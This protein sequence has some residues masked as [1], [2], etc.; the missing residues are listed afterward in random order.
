MTGEDIKTTTWKLSTHCMR[1]SCVLCTSRTQCDM[2]TCDGH[3][4]IVCMKY[5][6]PI[7]SWVHGLT[8]F[9]SS[10]LPLLMLW[11]QYSVKL[12]HYRA[13]VG[14]ICIKP[15]QSNRCE[16]NLWMLRRQLMFPDPTDSTRVLAQ[17]NRCMHIR[18]GRRR[19][20]SVSESVHVNCV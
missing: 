11:T 1:S 9:C 14:H 10:F 18:K 7:S 19:N 8:C 13:E 16:N 3:E 5:M 15:W 2:P 20:P 6:R 12:S 4:L 17:I